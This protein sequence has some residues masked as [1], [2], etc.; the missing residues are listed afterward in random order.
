MSQS[1]NYP[2][3]LSLQLPPHN[4]HSLVGVC[5]QTNIQMSGTRESEYTAR[6]TDPLLRPGRGHSPAYGLQNESEEG[7]RSLESGKTSFQ[8]ICHPGER[9]FRVATCCLIACLASLLVGM[10]LGFSSATLVELQNTTS[11]EIDNT[12]S[13]LFAVSRLVPHSHTQLVFTICCKSKSGL[14][15]Q[16]LSLKEVTLEVTLYLAHN[17][18]I[19][20]TT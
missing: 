14:C 1:H 12:T 11:T 5:C 4:T 3:V 8:S 17:L 6:D 18:N 7:E 16:Q 13:N 19:A 20:L 2:I 10:A 9:V 15:F